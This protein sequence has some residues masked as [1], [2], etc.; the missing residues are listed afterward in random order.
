MIAWNEVLKEIALVA[1]SITSKNPRDLIL[2]FTLPHTIIYTNNCEKLEPVIQ[3]S[4][5]AVNFKN[6]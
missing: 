2:N 6:K 4:L 3:S 5:S 1:H